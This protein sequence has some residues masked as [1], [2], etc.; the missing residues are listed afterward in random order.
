[1]N[2]KRVFALAALILL[3][4]PLATTHAGVFIG[5]GVPYPYYRPYYY[6][7]YW[8]GPRVV[9]APAPIVVAPPP[10]IVGPGPV[11]VAVQPAPTVIQTQAMQPV[12]PTLPAAP[13][14]AAAPAP[15][16]APSLYGH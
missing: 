10:V 11:P 15:G 6:R 16:P 3:S 14:P 12:T 2:G 8:Y 13:I 5:V 9:I 1:M 7:P 4:L